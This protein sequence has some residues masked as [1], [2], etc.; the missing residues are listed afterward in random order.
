MGREKSTWAWEAVQKMVHV[1][2]TWEFELKAEELEKLQRNT[3]AKSRMQGRRGED[4]VSAR[5][6]TIKKQFRKFSL[7]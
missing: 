3:E 2:F 5:H 7:D 1:S 6:R 4:E